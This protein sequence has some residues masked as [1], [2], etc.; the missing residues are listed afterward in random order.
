MTGG[1]R[2][3]RKTVDQESIKEKSPKMGAKKNWIQHL[4]HKIKLSILINKMLRNS[5]R[6]MEVKRKLGILT[7]IFE[8]I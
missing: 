6:G 2:A 3:D 4:V 7:F 1:M 8:G 5:Y